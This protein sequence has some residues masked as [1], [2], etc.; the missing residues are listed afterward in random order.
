MIRLFKRVISNQDIT[1]INYIV[2]NVLNKTVKYISSNTYIFTKN[3]IKSNFNHVIIF[4]TFS[5]KPITF[6]WNIIFLNTK[7]EYL[8]LFRIPE[9]HVISI[10]KQDRINL[11]A[12]GA[13]AP[14]RQI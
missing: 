11:D 10:H 12:K 3:I 2:Y 13:F 5:K 6:Y 4:S 8:Y 9:L 14:G 1:I 7:I